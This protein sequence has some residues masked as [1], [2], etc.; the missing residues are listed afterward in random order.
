MA[1]KWL[2]GNKTYS[3]TPK[4]FQCDFLSDIGKLPTAHRM[5][6]KQE[7]DTISDDPCMPGS[8]CFCFE[9]GS[10]WLL[11]IETDTWIKVGYKFGGS[12]GNTGSSGTGGTNVTSYNQLED[13]PLQ[14]ISG[15]TSTPLI[16][17][18]LQS[19]IYKIAGNF[20][21]TNNQKIMYAGISGD[22]FMISNEKIMQMASDGITLYNLKSDSTYTV[23]TYASKDNISTEILEQLNNGNFNSEIESIVNQKLSYATDVDIDNFFK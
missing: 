11:G 14:N 13:I 6:G 23:N 7:N 8:E 15:R 1:Y 10:I 4:E 2:K 20:S 19:G 9:D 22:I 17:S 12:S 3:Y 5:G 18:N 16:L 21:V